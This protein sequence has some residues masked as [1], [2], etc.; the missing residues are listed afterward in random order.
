MSAL[1]IRPVADTL[2]DHLPRVLARLTAE[3]ARGPNASFVPG[4]L[5]SYPMAPAIISGVGCICT[6]AHI[7]HSTECS[8]LRMIRDIDD[9]D[10]C[11][12]CYLIHVTFDLSTGDAWQIDKWH[13]TSAE[14]CRDISTSTVVGPKRDY[15]IP[16]VRVWHQHMLSAIE[17]HAPH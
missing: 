12:D 6:I 7:G 3:Y 5:A 17:G 10:D 15:F 9:G 2:L 8:M 11:T 14:L 16:F 1:A 4:V 13:A